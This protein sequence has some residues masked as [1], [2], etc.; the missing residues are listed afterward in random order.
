MHIEKLA[1][2]HFKNY[3]ES[4][5][6][7]SPEVNC[8]VGANG[9][10]KTNILDAIYYL[11]MCKSYLNPIDSQNILFDK[12]FFLLQGTWIKNEEQN[13]IYCAVK[14]G[15]KKVFKKNKVAYDK[16]A[17]HIGQYP[18]VMIS[19][20]DRN[21]ILE[22]S[23]TRRKWMDGIIAQFNRDYLECLIKYS[24]VLEQR[25]ALL[26]NMADFGFFNPESID[27]WDE[28]LMLYGSKIYEIRKDFLSEFI[29][30]FQKFYA[31]ISAEKEAVELVYKSQLHD[32][33]F[34]KL[35]KQATKA[36]FRKQ[37]TTVGIHK[38]D[39]VF[40]IKNQPVKKFGSQG[41][42]KSFLIALKLS[43]FEWLFKHLGVKPVLLLDDIFDKLDNQ[44]VEKLM[45]MVS[46][47]DFGQVMIT[48]TD[49]ERIRT[50]FA[51]IDKG[52]KPF[53]VHQNEVTEAEIVKP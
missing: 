4:E 11:S 14:K 19:P 31:V 17:D 10:G 28:Q 25:N 44:R 24:K 1:L 18:V 38:D 29:P 12:A 3:E 32:T 47:N 49:L 16:L 36:D 2:I 26:K 48:D 45:E 35:I 51:S 6:Q 41:Q 50:I 52:F 39:L 30:V 37:Y 7:F 34:D 9:A 13:H 22:G 43:Q 27:V 8:F 23:E 42:Q 40:T 53:V 20:Y 15:T 33:R 21:L 5:I 46:N